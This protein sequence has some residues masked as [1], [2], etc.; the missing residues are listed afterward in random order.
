MNLKDVL[1]YRN[2]C[3]ICYSQMELKTL[4]LAGV[5][6]QRVNDGLLIET[7]LKGVAVHFKYDGTYEKMKRWNNLYAKPM[8]LLKECP[9]CI[10]P[11]D[12]DYKDR[13]VV[14]KS[15]SIGASTLGTLKDKRCA[16]TI[17]LFGDSEGNFASNL[18]WEDIKYNDGDNFY[19][20]NTKFADKESHLFSGSFKNDSLDSMF[21]LTVP[22]VNAESIQTIDQLTHKFKI[23]TLFS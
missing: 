11:I 2:R 9:N 20:I 5:T 4:D 13:K 10:P 8:S 6:I 1:N 14:L 3:L 16:Y 7:G 17:T 19:H 23:Y 22:A 15:R 12:L 21:R 18:L